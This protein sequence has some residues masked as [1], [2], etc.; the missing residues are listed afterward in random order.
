MSWMI[1]MRQKINFKYAR[2]FFYLTLLSIPGI[3]F[4][5]FDTF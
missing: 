4:L 2:I 5:E 3:I 1:N